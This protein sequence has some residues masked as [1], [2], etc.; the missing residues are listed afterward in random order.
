MPVI[1][2]S[3]QT[4]YIFILPFLLIL[5][6]CSELTD[7]DNEQIQSALQ[8]SLLTTTESWDVQ[9]TLMEQGVR[10]VQIEGS[11]AVTYSRPGNKKTLINGP[12]YVQLFDTAGVMETEAWSRRAIYHEER[13]EFELFDSVRVVTVQ[14]NRLFSEYLMW[15]KKTGQI[16]SPGFVLVITLT[17]SIAGRKFTG[18]TDLVDYIIEEPR[19]E[20]IVD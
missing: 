13:S 15:E 3:V 16:T 18:T 1:A 5:G 8:D 19:G 2:T 9:M 14:N 7:Y 17:D 12:V 20:S 10:K 11:H 6:A 4:K